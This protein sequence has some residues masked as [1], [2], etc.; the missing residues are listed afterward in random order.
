MLDVP[1]PGWTGEG[2]SLTNQPFS[3]LYGKFGLN[4]SE[5][6]AFK[7]SWM[8]HEVLFRCKNVGRQRDFANF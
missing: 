4:L 3:S 7:H 2:I 6:Q 5:F 1:V 8:F